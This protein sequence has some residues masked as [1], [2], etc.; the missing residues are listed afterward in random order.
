[1]G[2][3]QGPT[4]TLL[5]GNAWWFHIFET[6][7]IFFDWNQEFVLYFKYLLW[8]KT[9][10]VIAWWFHIFETKNMGLS[11]NSVPLNPMVNDHYPY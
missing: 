11:E 9:H 5:E 7:N 10:M 3:L 2:Y 4:V 6:K 1:M 8:L